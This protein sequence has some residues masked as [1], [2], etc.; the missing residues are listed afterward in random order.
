MIW[1]LFL[2][3]IS[4]AD[5]YFVPKKPAS[6]DVA[7]IDHDGDLDIVIG[8]EYYD[9]WSGISVLT[10]N[11]KGTF[12]LTDSIYYG[13][14]HSSLHLL[15]LDNNDSYDIITEYYDNVEK[16]GLGI[17]FDFNNN[18]HEKHYFL[19]S[20]AG[21]FK[22]GD[23]DS[24]NDIDVSFFSNPFF[25]WGYIKNIG[26]EEF[27]TPVYY[28]LDYPPQDMAVGDLNGDKREDI[29]IGG[30]LDS[31]LNYETGLQY[32][33]IPD[34]A[35]ASSCIEI[36]DIDNDGDNDI[37]GASWGMPGS[38]K[39]FVIYT[40][41][42]IGN[43]ELTFTKWINEALSEI[44]ISD[45]NN[46]NY[47]DI[48][49]NVSIY[50]NNSEYELSHTY[51]LYNNQDG[52]FKDPV[53][54]Y[55]GIC[56]H[57]SYAADLDGNGLNDIVTLNYDFYLPHPENGTIHIL[58][59][60]SLG[61]FVEDPVSIEDDTVIRDYKLEQ[62]YPNPF[63]NQTNI[64]YQIK[65]SCVVELNVFNS[66]GEFVKNLVT[67]KQIKG[68]Y[69]VVFNASNLNSGVYYYRLKTKRGVIET[70]KMLYLR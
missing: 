43:F 15:K 4:Y 48:I 67:D 58:F 38:P 26:N 28:D 68:K 25:F 39:K 45:L 62:N 14:N 42:G 65:D 19:N 7:D 1:I 21:E 32:F 9:N 63:N 22:I 12:T 30:Y 53:N 2:T 13:G 56:S 6:V 31:W 60:D 20:G 11:G 27:S 50:Y 23:I 34:T 51:I 24:D 61:N 35:D 59:Q 41:D 69:S 3:N 16:T 37:I 66:K 29:L 10:N 36:A 8:H 18:M 40:N 70:K 64:E 55:T 49:Y 33:S 57:I 44:F 5:E 47:P 46:D 52:T 17:I 54:Y